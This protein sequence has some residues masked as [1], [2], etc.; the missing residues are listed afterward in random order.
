MIMRQSGKRRMKNLLLAAAFTA[1][2]AS[3]A[4]VSNVHK[5]EA[6][7]G[8]W[9]PWEP[10]NYWDPVRISWRDTFDPEHYFFGDLSEQGGSVY[11]YTRI[12][13]SVLFGEKFLHIV[14][15][16]AEQLGIDIID[17]LHLDP[18]IMNIA[19][20]MA[21]EKQSRATELH[22]TAQK[23]LLTESSSFHSYNEGHEAYE[24]PRNLVRQRK[25]IS[26]SAVKY[27]QIAESAIADGDRTRETVHRLVEAAANAKGETELRQIMEQLNAI[28]VADQS[29][30]T[31]LLAA[32]VQLE[33][34]QRQVDLDKEIEWEK[35]AQDAKII[36]TDPYNEERAAVSGYEREKPRGFVRFK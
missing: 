3:G 22:S 12:I 11:D 30:V 23:D 5:G 7:G 26:A 20:S 6:W 18:M 24:A 9:R 4:L 33:N 25:E 16:I 29:Q 13:K 28:S 34:D 17:R 36:V 35:Q 27:A 19:T 15:N 1:A 14:E 31:A 32:K 2:A 8:W 21:G 10:E